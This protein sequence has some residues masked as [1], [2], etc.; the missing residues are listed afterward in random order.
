[1]EKLIRTNTI[2]NGHFLSQEG[3]RLVVQDDIHGGRYVSLIDIISVDRAQQAGL[4]QEQAVERPETDVQRR[5]KVACDCRLRGRRLPVRWRDTEPTR[6]EGMRVAVI[7]GRRGRLA[8]QRRCL[9]H[10][11][12]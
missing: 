1:M 12:W 2:S 8:C 3:L 4:R 5:R 10:D 6:T 9:R 11:M 7:G